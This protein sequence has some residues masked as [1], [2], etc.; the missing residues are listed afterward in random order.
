MAELIGLLEELP[1]NNEV[2]VDL[3]LRRTGARVGATELPSLP[4]SMLGVLQTPRQSGG[5]GLTRG[6]NVVRERIPLDYVIVGSRTLLLKV[7]R[8]AR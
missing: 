6:T 3:F 5:T 7:D 4:T 1:R 2:V 8:R